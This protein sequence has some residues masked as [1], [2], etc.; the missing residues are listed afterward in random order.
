MKL[1]SMTLTFEDNFKVVVSVYERV[2]KQGIILYCEDI[3]G[4][5][6]PGKELDEAL[7]NLLCAIRQ[8]RNGEAPVWLQQELNRFQRN[9]LRSVG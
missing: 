3:M 9:K 6:G 8:I 5:Y 2:D 4:A 1:K 7:M